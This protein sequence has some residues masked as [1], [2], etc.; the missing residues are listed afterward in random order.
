M[1]TEKKEV[2]LG[3]REFQPNPST[4]IAQTLV[5]HEVEYAFGVQ[6]GHI[7]QMV[8]EISNAGI[9][10]ITFCHEATAV[11]AAEAYSKVTRKPGV[12]YATVGPG[13]GNAISAI[14]Q[15]YQSCSPVIFLAGG[16]APEVDMLPTIQPSYIMDLCRQITRWS[17]RVTETAQIKQ[18]IARAFK[19]SLYYPKL[20]IALE[21]E[22]GMLMKPLPPAAPAGL[23]GADAL[24]VEKWRGAETAQPLAPG[25]DPQMIERAIKA[26]WE[27]KKPIVYA[28]DG[29]HWSDAGAELKEFAELSQIPVT[30]RRIARGCFSEVHPLFV[31]SRSGRA[32]VDGSD[33]RLLLGAKVG[34]FDGFG[35]GWPAT[36]QVNESAAHIWTYINTPVAIV[37]SPKIV[38]RQMI[39]YIKGNKLK[40]PAH[41][42]EW[43]RFS[44]DCQQGGQEERIG[45]AEKYRNHKP[46]HYGYLAKK[47]WDVCENLYGGMN[48]V[49]IDGYSISDYAPAFLKARYSGQVMDAS[50]YAGVGHGVGM[51]IG[52]AFGDPDAKKHPILALMGDAGMRLAGMDYETALIHKLPIVYLVTENQGWLTGMKYVWYGKN[53]EALGPQ[54]REYGTGEATV[55]RYD[56]LCEVFGGHGEH[57]DDPAQIEQALTRA[58]RS[59]EQGVPAIVNVHMDPRVSNRQIYSPMYTAVWSHIPWDR[60]AKRGKACRRAY[61]KQ[62]PWDELGVPK[63]P[64]PD[65]WEPVGDDEDTP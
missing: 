63:M 19:D 9:K 18:I 62:F 54:D 33:M 27:A 7:W 35:M 2:P 47:A 22:L 12:C 56:K 10:N 43:V 52:A 40:P 21:M 38:L 42:A 4:L 24:Y 13:V 48:R 16:N 26:L 41:R 31:D 49:I 64:L 58:F 5:E 51:A 11:Y 65:P 20:P 60:L 61:M 37:G 23:Y 14:Q 50:E 28:A 32:A 36:I 57:V 44:Q 34:T 39:D 59:A 17:E 30:T 1:S 15:A 25:G 55:A 53:W 46:V 29:C 6:G 45:K 8:D 3:M